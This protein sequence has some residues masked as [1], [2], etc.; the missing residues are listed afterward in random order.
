MV[1]LLSLSLTACLTTGSDETRPVLTVNTGCESFKAIYWSKKDTR[2]T[3]EQ[4]VE[5]NAVYKKLCMDK[6]N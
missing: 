2:K 5:H 6:K 4:V 1:L 3:Q